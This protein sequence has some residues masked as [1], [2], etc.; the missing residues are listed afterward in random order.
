MFGWLKKKDPS[1]MPLPSER[2]AK[3][4]AY[5][6]Y[7]KDL[8]VA[9]QK[10]SPPAVIN[11]DAWRDPNPWHPMT[12]AVDI[13]HLGKLIEELSECSSAAA[14]CII[15]GVDEKEPVTGKLNRHWLE[16]EVA[17]VRANVELVTERFQL[18]RARMQQ[19]VEIKLYHLRK[20]HEM[21]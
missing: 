3:A 1:W 17:D 12:D 6:Q 15:Q 20:W 4:D 10:R 14:R 16:E 18:D 2:K 7:D 5:R 21:A 9:W 11:A 13:K 8:S 19:R